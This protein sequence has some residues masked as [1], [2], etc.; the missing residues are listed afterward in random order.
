[1][2]DRAA[3]NEL[4]MPR[5][6]LSL[7]AAQFLGALNDN[8]FKFFLVFSLIQIHGQD[9]TSRINAVAGGV[10]V[11]PFLLF[12]AAAGVAADRFPKRRVIVIVKA[13]EVAVMGFG[14]WAFSTGADVI[15][16]AVLFF[17]ALQSAFFGPS[18]YGVVPELVG[19]A[20]LSRA[21]GFLS[22]W[23]YLAIILGTALAPWLGTQFDDR[24]HHAAFVCVAFSLIGLCVALT[25]PPTEAARPHA[26][27]SFWFPRDIIRT[28][29]YV[30]RDG[31]LMLALLASAYFLLIGAFLQLNIMPYGIQALGLDE[32]ESTYLFLLCAMGIGAGS[33]LAGRLSGR[34]VEFGLVPIGA[35]GLMASTLALWRAP[36]SV[37]AVA[38]FMALTGVSAG[39]FIV[40][41]NAFIQFR[42]PRERLGEVL[43]ASSF[44]SWIGVLLASIFL[45]LFSEVWGLEA[46]TGFLIVGTLTLG[47]TVITFKVLPDFFL[48]FVA[49]A[50]TRTFYR[51]R[52]RGLENV[53]AQGPALLVCNHIGWSDAAIM[54]ATMPRR[55]KFLMNRQVYEGMGRFR[56]VFDLAGVIPIAKGD[57]RSQIEDSLKA[58]RDKL[59]EGYIVCIF[60]EGMLSRTGMMQKFKTGYARILKGTD[61]PL[62][63]VYLGGLWG[64]V[65][66]YYHSD[67]ILSRFPSRLPYPVTVIFGEPMSPD[68]DRMVV[69]ERVQEL[70]VEYFA[71][72]RDTCRPLGELALRSARKHWTAR[73]LS[74]TTGQSRTFGEIAVGG[75]ALSRVFRRAL[76]DTPCVGLALPASVGGVLANLGLTLAGKV[77]VNL[78]LSAGPDAIAAMTDRARLR[79]VITVGRLRAVFDDMPGVT[80]LLVEDLLKQLTGMDK[81]IGYVAARIAPASW[82]GCPRDWSAE[83]VATVLF[84][85]G[86]TGQ[87]K[88]VQLTHYNLVSNIESVTQVLRLH[89]ADHICGSLPFFHAFGFTCT[90]WLPLIL[91]VTVTYHPN[92]LEIGKVADLI[93]R[94]QCTLM[95]TTPTMLGRFIKKAEPGD[96]ASLRHCLVGAEPLPAR[97]VDA[98]TAKFGHIPYEGYGATELSPMAII[99]IPDAEVDN[100]VQIGHKPGTVGHPVPGVAV[101][102]V[103]PDTGERRKYGEPGLLLIKG[104]NVMRGYLDDDEA[105]ANAIRDGWYVTGD[106]AAMDMDGFV[107]ITDRLARFSKL[108]G[109]MVPH[110]AVEDALHAAVDAE[111]TAFAVAGVPD[112][113]KGERLVVLYAKDAV[114]L[115]TLRAALAEIDLPNLWKP[116]PGA[117][118]PVDEIPVMKTGKLDLGAIREL[119]RSAVEDDAGRA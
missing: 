21:N 3:T 57:G 99:N 111:G 115:D 41:L 119:A 93:K 95:I 84:S 60:A 103:D 10:F 48:R 113:S 30:S 85:S 26:R 13:M 94:A 44:M 112:E 89:D 51:L 22:A 55:I 97:V 106:I 87:P 109:E 73:G 71:D 1:M 40:P 19:S 69:R 83:D 11:I 66:S 74:D 14:V 9:A 105:T 91:G 116:K 86:S 4:R 8:L 34:N 16:Y 101:K 75:V 62:I 72:R 90:L 15:L 38:V 98:F 45:Y 59:D 29:K 114:S 32:K 78:N 25:L 18:K 81:A 76:D 24:Y 6:F 47:L 7:N 104:P 52:V 110:R 68:T 56:W 100:K 67:R 54:V 5:S 61:H 42:T 92:P 50:V 117:F 53:P 63:P 37:G 35:F 80:V 46:R 12:L 39:I 36:S 102:I 43:A 2:T 96:L 58:A 28:L 118:Y 17:M 65:F 88:G 31:F 64:S 27:F 107:T 108:G 33:V 49:A 70:S 20:R 77:P 79:T 82:A 23:T